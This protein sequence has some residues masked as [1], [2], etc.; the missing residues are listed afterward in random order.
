[1]S[2]YIETELYIAPHNPDAAD[3]LSAILADSGYES[4][5]ETENGI[6][7][8]IQKSMYSDWNVKEAIKSLP[9]KGCTVTYN[10]IF[11]K[12]E[13][14]N[15]RW[16]EENFT[17]I[18]IG[19]E[20]IIHSPKHIIDEYAKHEILIAPK[21]AFG[22]GHHQT[23]IMMAEWVLSE[24]IQNKTV[25]DMGCGT[26]ILAILASKCGAAKVTAIDID[27]RAYKNAIENTRLNHISN[28]YLRHGGAEAIESN[29]FDII[30]ANI[31]RN[32]LISDM[33][34]YSEAVNPGGVLY[35]SGFYES[36]INILSAAASN[37]G[38]AKAKTK[39]D[40]EWASVKYIKT[41]H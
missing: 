9:I 11:I 31:N 28:I 30:L 1:M 39:T 20:C 36:D 8:Y 40:G 10:N 41:T 18:S 24:N 27:E 16:V 12:D 22:S 14:W 5:I 19:K 6:K 37:T 34:I 38:F 23:T 26:G 32:I 35:V 7:C 29:K 17:P 3:I 15:S 21:M 13:D 33:E 25:L 4:F 2:G